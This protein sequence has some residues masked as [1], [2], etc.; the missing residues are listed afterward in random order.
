MEAF[1]AQRA[2]DL[3]LVRDYG[4]SLL[5]QGQ[6]V[7]PSDDAQLALRATASLA[8]GGLLLLALAVPRGRKLVFET[9]ETVLAVALIIVLLAAVLGLPLG[10][11]PTAAACVKV[12]PERSPE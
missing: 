6:L 3:R 5:A 12:P 2:A 9:V 11:P 8:L 10:A 4:A 7:P 1:L